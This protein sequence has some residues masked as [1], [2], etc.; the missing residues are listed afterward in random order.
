MQ[1]RYFSVL[2]LRRH[3][4]A[5]LE[6]PSAISRQE[7]RL[8]GSFE[9]PEFYGALREP[10][11]RAVRDLHAGPVVGRKGLVQVPRAVEAPLCAANKDT[12]WRGNFS[13]IEESNRGER[14]ARL[15]ARV[16]KLFKALAV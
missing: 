11:Q 9:L 1:I 8:S 5:C 16:C 2:P 12:W 15:D 6:V 4:C 10:E 3:P 13:E 14:P 7:E